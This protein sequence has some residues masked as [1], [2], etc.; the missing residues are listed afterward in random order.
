MIDNDKR[1]R[2]LCLISVDT[3]VIVFCRFNDRVHSLPAIWARSVIDDIPN[4]EICALCRAGKMIQRGMSRYD[5][6]DFEWRTIEPILPDKPRGV[7]RV[8][9]R[10]VLNGICWVLP[11]GAPWRDVPERYGPN[12]TC[13]NR[14][15]RWTTV[16]VWDHRLHARQRMIPRSALHSGIYPFASHFLSELQLVSRFSFGACD[17]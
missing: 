7:S 14:F 2:F 10:R 11:S 12:T 6:T 16:D 9:D 5:L 17:V 3:A 1:G 4:H 15:R 13:Y 8:D